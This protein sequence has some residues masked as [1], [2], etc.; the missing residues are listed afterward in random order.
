MAKH[1]RIAH[2]PD[3]D[4]R[5]M[6]W[7][8]REG[9]IENTNYTFSFQEANTAELNSICKQGDVEI[10]AIS[11]AYYAKAHEK[12]QPLLMGSSVGDGYGPVVVTKK[13]SG[14]KLSL[15]AMNSI[16]LLSPGL[17]TTAH[18]VLT[19]GLGYQF[20]SVE[21]VSIS[22]MERVFQ[23]LDTQT[24]PCAALLIHEGRLLF[25]NFGCERLLDL[26]VD[27]EQKTGTSLPLGIN[28]ISRKLEQSEREELSQLLQDSFQYAAKHRDEFVEIAQKKDSPYFTDLNPSELKDYL[29][30]YANQT[31]GS[32]SEKDKKAM[33]LL[34][35]GSQVE[36]RI[37][38]D[39]I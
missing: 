23:V 24:E 38:I 6:F 11:A 17:S 12:W 25:E 34:I 33:D 5:F 2:S 28:V 22:P 35:N 4:D 37:S 18:T 29:D 26:G 7:P 32:M 21:E 10:C 20:K 30:L 31:T 16:K 15:G 9:L 36:N 19:K 8:L 13:G 1:I 39:W 14:V 3:A 27:W